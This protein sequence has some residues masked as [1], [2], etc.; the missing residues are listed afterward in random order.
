MGE[1]FGFDIAVQNR[2]TTDATGIQL[3][4]DLPDGVQG[5]SV[6]K[7]GPRAEPDIRQGQLQY[8]FQP[9]KRIQPGGEMTFRINLKATKPISNGVVN[10]RI[11]YDQMQKELVTSEAITASDD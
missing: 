5:V 7:G 3:T 1:E 9:V 2:G 10:A 11:S 6:G 8:R 4:I